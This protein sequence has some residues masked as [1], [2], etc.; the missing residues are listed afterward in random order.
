MAKATKISSPDALEQL[1]P[2]SAPTQTPAQTV[3][4]SAKPTLSLKIPELPTTDGPKGDKS[5]AGKYAQEI[6]KQVGA[7]M[8]DE[9]LVRDTSDSRMPAIMVVRAMP[10]AQKHE[11]IIGKATR[12]IYHAKFPAHN[13]RDAIPVIGEFLN[14]EQVMYDIDWINGKADVPQRI[15]DIIV[16]EG[17]Q[18]LYRI[19]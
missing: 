17:L 16:N 19:N 1:L 3:S 12:M 11:S 5:D 18:G 6:R 15:V 9:V 8:G 14:G 7:E 13:G 4:G 10:P 2:E